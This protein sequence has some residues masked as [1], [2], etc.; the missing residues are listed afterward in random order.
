MAKFSTGYTLGFAVAVCVVCSLAVASASIGLRPYQKL[1]E[2]REVES[3]ILAA[4]GL[5]E[6]DAIVLKGEA[7]D[8]MYAERV[9]PIVIDSEGKVL[10][11]RT[12]EEVKAEAKA[13]KSEK[14]DPTIHAVYLRKDGETIAA[15]AIPV[16]GRGLWGPISGYLAIAPDG[17]T[18]SGATFFAPKETP[19]LGYEIVADWFTDRFKGK[20]VYAGGEAKPIEVVKG[21]VSLACPG[22][23][24]IHCVDGISGSTLTCRGVTAMLADGIETYD[25]YLERVRSG[26]GR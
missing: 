17:E 26:G 5:P 24:G 12:V 20:K 25:P 1:N 2:K 11:D 18:V 4:L 16:A 14:R 21:S 3:K 23:A 9:Q 8:E 6:D 19:G 22:D 15:Y 13:A 7:V 10:P